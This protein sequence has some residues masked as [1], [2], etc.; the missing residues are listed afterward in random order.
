MSDTAVATSIGA[1]VGRIANIAP[2][3]PDA[4]IY[5]AGFASTDALELLVELED[6]HGVV[7]PDGAFIEARTT[8]DLARLV[9]SLQTGGTP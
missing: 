8:G 6:A 7:I 4:D 3:P 5:A 9:T 2:P 1:R